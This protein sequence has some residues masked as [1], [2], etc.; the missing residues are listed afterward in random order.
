MDAPAVSE[1]HRLMTQTHFPEPSPDADR[2]GRYPALTKL[3]LS[4]RDFAALSRQGSVTLE[5]RQDRTYYKLRFR[6]CGRQIVLYVGGT[7]QAALVSEELKALQTTRRLERELDKLGR[8][9][10]QKLRDSKAALEPLL[11]ERGF[12]FHGRAIRRPRRPSKYINVS[13]L[14]SLDKEVNHEQCRGI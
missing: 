13:F 4:E 3:G 11:L 6:A 7:E 8:A 2:L 9:T 12:R 14:N 1:T 10:R 5:R